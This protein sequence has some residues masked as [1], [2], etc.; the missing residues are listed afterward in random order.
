MMDTRR[1][2]GPPVPPRRAFTLVEL[3]VVISIL[4]LLLA[5]LA[6]SLS[7]ARAVA[8]DSICRSNLGQLS[9]AH[10]LY[11]TNA[12]GDFF[13]YNGSII[14]MAF[15]EKYHKIHDVRL[16]PDAAKPYS[17]TVASRGSSQHAWNAW[18]RLGSYGVNGWIYNPSD[19][20]SNG[21]AGGRAYPCCSRRAFPDPWWRGIGDVGYP[22]MTPAY[23]DSNWVDGWP[24]YD[25][26]V[27]PV[28]DGSITDPNE[29][30]QMS[31]F[32]FDRHQMAINVAL[33][34]GHVDHVPLGQLWSLMWSKTHQQTTM[35]IP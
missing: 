35:I 1:T 26:I 21:N 18:S 33:L 8:R 28:L 3:L 15:L 31:R 6:P 4:S 19:S 27:P 13:P 30:F 20:A 10:G 5:L 9:I 16:C 2:S 22:G 24:W 12:R 17:P 7:R 23:A 34:D 29:R 25:D 11:V 32:C 14:Y